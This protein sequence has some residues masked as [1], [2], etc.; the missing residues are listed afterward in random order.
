METLLLSHVSIMSGSISI[1]A[2]H[3]DDSYIKAAMK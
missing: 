3:D 1:R 2:G